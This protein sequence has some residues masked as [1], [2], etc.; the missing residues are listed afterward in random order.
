MSEYSLPKIF[1]SCYD[2]ANMNQENHNRIFITNSIDI[3]GRQPDKPEASGAAPE[4]DGDGAA[5]PPPCIGK[6]T[7]WLNLLQNL[8]SG[9]RI[10]LFRRVA[11]DDFC[12]AAGELALLAITDFVLNLIVS[13]VLIGEGGEFNYFA[14]SSFFFHLP[15]MLLCGLLA[16][17]LL[18]RPALV[19]LVPVALIS[20]SIPIELCHG[21]LEGLSWL[22]RME[23]LERYLDAPHYY[24]FFWWWTAAAAL[25]LVRL[26]PI[27]LSRR[28]TLLLFFTALLVFP[29]FLYPRGDLWVNGEE[30]SE[31]GELS[32]TEE[33]LT[34]QSRLLDKQLSGLLPGGKRA[35]E[36]YF[37][38]FAGDATQD[39]F[40]RELMAVERLMKERFS[41]AGRTVTLVNN[42]RTATSLP[43]ATAT[44]LDRA[45]EVLGRVMNRDEDVLF[46]YLTSHG[47][48]EQVVA[49]DN[50]PLELDGLTPEMVRRMLKK[51]G[52]RWKVLVVSACYAGGFV[53]PLKDD[54]T[55]IITAAD[56]THESFGC[57]YGEE[58]TWFGNAYFN[59]ALRHSYSFTAAFVQAQETIRKW[60]AE[61]GETP[62][63]PQIW[64]GKRMEQKL[65]QLENRRGRE[66]DKLK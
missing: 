41:A 59:Q 36:L 16:G 10:A 53:E 60:E 23:W 58:F 52:V 47:S 44:N 25:F 1:I 62:S 65:V 28:I 49:V 31:S 11:A 57:S 64:V 48:P 55:L 51:S 39:V 26:T 50:G 9:V 54:H 29:L 33:V 22:H 19:M 6:S 12:P 13:F 37:V 34:A 66:A 21:A 20:L 5:A 18:G 4:P 15:L 42:P 45:L 14:F 7:P 40:M 63:N 61:Q 56:A 43:F 46:L 2:A 3:H 27:N 32:L 35:P 8:R 30:K 17:R 24:R 38:G